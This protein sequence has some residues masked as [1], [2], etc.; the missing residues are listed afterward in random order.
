[1]VYK[2]RVGKYF[3]IVLY[4]VSVRD[5]MQIIHEGMMFSEGGQ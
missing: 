5:Y 4:V 2:G 1:M 3:Y